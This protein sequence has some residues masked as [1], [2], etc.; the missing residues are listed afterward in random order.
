MSVDR[1]I[2]Y[3]TFNVSEWLVERHVDEGRGERIAIRSRGR[4]LSYHDL[5]VEIERTATGLLG[6]G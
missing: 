6:L 3:E 4:S 5:L 2:M 1:G